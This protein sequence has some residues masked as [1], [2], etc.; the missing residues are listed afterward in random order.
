MATYNIIFESEWE[1]SIDGKLRFSCAEQK[2][3][4]VGEKVG[5]G[6]SVEKSDENEEK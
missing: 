5:G 2:G 3:L 6:N 1:N 4:N